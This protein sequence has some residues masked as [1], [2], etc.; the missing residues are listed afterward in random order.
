M[1]VR[2]RFRDLVRRGASGCRTL[3][4]RVCGAVKVSDSGLGRLLHLAAEEER[5][6]A[7]KEVGSGS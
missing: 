6:A 2:I 5:L 4:L 3:Q 7:Q 1:G